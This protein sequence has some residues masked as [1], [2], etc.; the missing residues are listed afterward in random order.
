M[1]YYG[2]EEAYEV[3]WSIYEMPAVVKRVVTNSEAERIVTRRWIAILDRVKQLEG[4]S[5]VRR[6]EKE[7]FLVVQT[8]KGVSVE[9]GLNNNQ[10]KH[11][12]ARARKWYAQQ[13]DVRLPYNVR[14]DMT[15][16]RFIDR[17][18]EIK[19][20]G[21]AGKRRKNELEAEESR[22]WT[23]LIV[24]WKGGQSIHE[25]PTLHARPRH[26]FLQ[27]DERDSKDILVLAWNKK[28]KPILYGGKEAY[29]FQ[30]HQT[31]AVI[32]GIV[33][34]NEADD[35]AARHH[36]ANS[37]LVR[38]HIDWVILHQGEHEI[39][40]VAQT[41]WGVPA[42]DA[43]IIDKNL[44]DE[45]LKI[46]QE[47]ARHIYSSVFGLKLPEHV[48]DRFTYIETEKGTWIGQVVWWEGVESTGAQP[49]LRMEPEIICDV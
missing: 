9:L 21:A 46:I 7:T 44:N 27:K 8:K 14:G 15:R 10:L 19:A 42:R 16:Y 6:G 40:L 41:W 34:N 23:G 29:P 49:V 45:K 25:L 5:V 38:Q 31:P 43:K 18:H 32:R 13:F 33:V 39:W 28:G 12:A 24:G 36:I 4:W 47:S 35:V 37:E 48:A 26:I 11:I 22:K 20:R 30:Y 2:G 1:E 17:G 3:P